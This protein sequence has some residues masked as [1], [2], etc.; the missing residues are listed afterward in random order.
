MWPMAD[1]APADML[2]RVIALE[3][4]D[5]VLEECRMVLP[6]AEPGWV[7]N[8]YWMARVGDTSAWP[9]R[10]SSPDGAGHI[11]T[12]RPHVLTRRPDLDVP[13]TTQRV[14][15]QEVIGDGCEG[16]DCGFCGGHPAR[17]RE[18]EETEIVR[19]QVVYEAP[20]G[21]VAIDPAYAPLTEGLD[22]RVGDGLA[23]G[24]AGLSG[25]HPLLVLMPLWIMGGA[26][27][28]AHR[29]WEQGGGNG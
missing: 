23:G 7:T 29:G 6:L 19:G 4:S 1:I 18:V 28:Q 26:I 14:T 12:K 5:L 22:L 27:V 16:C 25:D 11:A 15:R 21:V 20:W 13:S 2:C 3:G 24:I 8:G 17:T 9:A 10:R